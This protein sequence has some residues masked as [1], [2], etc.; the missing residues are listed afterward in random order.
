[1]H[2]SH[3]LRVAAWVFVAISLPLY[4]ASGAGYVR[5]A[6]RSMRAEDG[7]GKNRARG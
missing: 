2:P 1:V 5:A 4:Y 6:L 7:G 3:A